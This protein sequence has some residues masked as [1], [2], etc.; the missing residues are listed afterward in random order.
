MAKIVQVIS[1]Q[2]TVAL[3]L[4][5]KPGDMVAVGDTQMHSAIPEGQNLFPSQTKIADVPLLNNKVSGEKVIVK[6]D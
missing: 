2:G 1:P 6:V 3:L 5:I 4:P